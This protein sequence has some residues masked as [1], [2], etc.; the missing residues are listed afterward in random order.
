[1]G[2]PWSPDNSQHL[3]DPYSFT[4][5]LHG[6]VLAGLVAWATPR[7]SVPWQLCLAIA[8]EAGWEA[9]ENTPFVIGRYRATAALGYEGDAIVNSLGD[10]LA[11][12]LGVL[13]ARWLG[14]RRSLLV[15]AVVETAL[16]VWIRDS[17]LLNVVMLI[18]PFGWIKAWQAG[19]PR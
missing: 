10:I 18:H 9:I 12:G 2:N 19:F 8:L 11:C 3:F 13:L 14:V 16:L 15:F 6:F 5:L 17:L 7:L 4:H 1:V